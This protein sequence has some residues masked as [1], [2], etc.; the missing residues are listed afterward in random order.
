VPSSGRRRAHAASVEASTRGRDGASL[1][2]GT[3][4]VAS[5]AAAAIMLN[6]HACFWQSLGGAWPRS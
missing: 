4:T 5:R 2:G 6:V 3:S 1:A